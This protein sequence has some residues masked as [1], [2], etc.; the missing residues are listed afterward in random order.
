MR[1][2]PKSYIAA[3]YLP[4]RYLQGYSFCKLATDPLYKAVC[5]ELEGHQEPLLDLG[6]G[7]G[8][9]AQC[10]R[11]IHNPIQYVGVDSDAAKIEIAR[12]ASLKRNFRDTRF[13][14]YDLVQALP[15]H[16]GSVALLDVL[17][18]LAPETRQPLLQAVASRLSSSGKAIMRIGIED[19]SWRAAYA[20]GADR[21][22]HW[23]RW[24]RSSFVSLPTREELSQ[25][26]S[27]VGLEAQFRPLWGRT[28]FNNY[29]VI[30]TQRK[31]A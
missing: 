18:Y 30:A 7:I 4:D 9:L 6:C 12:A 1:K 29:L 15:E 2:I 19:Q 13:E 24:M 11:A 17:Q 28:P 26:L 14:V 16:K 10:L 22:G 8:L 25:A 31:G 23:I 5:A 3:T 21:F 27:G 20:R